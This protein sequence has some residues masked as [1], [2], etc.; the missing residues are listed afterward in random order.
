MHS[1]QCWLWNCQFYLLVIFGNVILVCALRQCYEASHTNV[2][3]Q[4]DLAITVL[5][6]V[7]HS[8]LQRTR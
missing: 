6:N 5:V 7:F 4:T 3:L 2:L 8:F 1:H